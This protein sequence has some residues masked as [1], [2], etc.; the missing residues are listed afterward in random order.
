MNIYY[1]SEKRITRRSEEIDANT[2]SIYSR[3]IG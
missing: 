2:K 3:R 1:L